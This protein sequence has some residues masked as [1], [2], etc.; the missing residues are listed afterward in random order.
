ML[1]EQISANSILYPEFL[2]P[3]SLITFLYCSRRR[4]SN[5]E[6]NKVHSLCG[7]DTVI[8]LIDNF[9]MLRGLHLAVD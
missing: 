8:Y 5:L 6:S 4:Q 7:T 9:F 3:E 2:I 1:Y